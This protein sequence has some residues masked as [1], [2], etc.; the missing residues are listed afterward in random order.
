MVT[1]FW[2]FYSSMK[3]LVSIVWLESDIFCVC[4][5]WSVEPCNSFHYKIVAHKRLLVKWVKRKGSWCIARLGERKI[6]KEIFWKTCNVT[7]CDEKNERIA[8]KIC[9]FILLHFCHFYSLRCTKE[10]SSDSAHH[11]FFRLN[12]YHLRLI[13][14]WHSNHAE[15]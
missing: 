5:E 7:Q 6:E 15:I 12:V 14:F 3:F 9:W 11:Y 1:H 2:A 10:W 4:C 13:F 8:I